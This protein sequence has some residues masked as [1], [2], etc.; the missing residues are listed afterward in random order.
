MA[1]VKS[2]YGS[3]AQAFTITLASLASGTGVYGAGRTSVAVDNTSN[4]FLDALVQVKVKTSAS[5]LTAPSVVYVYAYATVDGGT[6][7]GDGIAGT[8]SAFTAT[9]PPNVPLLGTI[10]CP[11]TSTTYISRVM[12]MAGAFGGVLPDH[13]GIFVVNFTGQAL[14]STAG[15]LSALWQG[16]YSTVI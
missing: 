6:T 16:V 8:D 10:N 3:N 7:Y 9:N 14:D 12:S 15:N 2:A 4:L 11:S 5:A 1:N 13:Y